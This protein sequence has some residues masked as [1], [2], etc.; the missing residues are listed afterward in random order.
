MLVG[1]VLIPVV[2]VPRYVFMAIAW[3]VIH[4]MQ[5]LEWAE[6]EVV[7]LMRRVSGDPEPAAEDDDSVVL[8]DDPD[9]I[10]RVLQDAKKPDHYPDCVCANCRSR[11]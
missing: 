8:L 2:T 10:D 4:I 11:L 7:R 1:L 9:L 6:A 3:L 5:G